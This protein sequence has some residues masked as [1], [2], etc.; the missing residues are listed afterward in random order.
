VLPGAYIIIVVDPATKCDEKALVVAGV[1]L[2]STFRKAFKKRS[3]CYRLHI[4]LLQFT[5]RLISA[6]KPLLVAG[7]QQ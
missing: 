6:Q 1:F 2:Y 5:R 3:K 4:K 7:S